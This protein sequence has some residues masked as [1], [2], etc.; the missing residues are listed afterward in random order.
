MRLFLVMIFVL[1]FSG[2]SAQTDSIV[3]VKDD[4]KIYSCQNENA[5]NW[6]VITDNDVDFT[7]I[8]LDIPI[9]EVRDWYLRKEDSQN[10]YRSTVFYKENQKFLLFKRGNNLDDQILF[11]IINN[12]HEKLTLYMRAYQETYYFHLL[13]L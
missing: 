4:L 10:F 9:G 12:S 5:L 6:Y 13:E 11:E 3:L 8:R 1:L 7:L 2:L